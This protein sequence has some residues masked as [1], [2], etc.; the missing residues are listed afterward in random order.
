MRLSNCAR[1]LVSHPTRFLGYFLVLAFFSGMLPDID[2]ILSRYFGI[3][4]S[5]F[6]HHSFFMVGIVFAGSGAILLV[7]CFC[8][9]RKARI[10]KLSGQERPDSAG[11][12]LDN[13]NR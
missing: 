11:Y 12:P 7:A 13:S 2:H 1:Y 4:Y 6:L 8:R 3:G 5:R 9:L 10:L